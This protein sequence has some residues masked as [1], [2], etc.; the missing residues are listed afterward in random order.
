MNADC[1][2]ELFVGASCV[3]VDVAMAEIHGS[4]RGR[5]IFI[6]ALVAEAR[7]SFPQAVL[8]WLH[9]VSTP[10]HR[11]R[12]GNVEDRGVHRWMTH[13]AHNP[14]DILARPRSSTAHPTGLTT[15]RPCA[16]NAI[17]KPGTAIMMMLP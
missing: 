2:R 12:H 11:E 10:F 5:V 3:I 15:I 16:M 14:D 8:R 4:S 13:T 1:R 6:E 7:K 17:T 9:P